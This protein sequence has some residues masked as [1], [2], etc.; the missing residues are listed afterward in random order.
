M[1]FVRLNKLRLLI[2]CIL[3][4]FTGAYAQSAPQTGA[5]IITAADIQREHPASVSDL[6]RSRAGSDDSSGTITM[7]GV[8]GVAVV[9]N[10]MPSTLSDVNH[11]NL[12][13]IERIEIYRG[14]ASARF[15]SNAMGGAIVVTTR[16]GAEAHSVL[17]L[18]G[19]SSGSLGARFGGDWNS[20]GWQAG[21]SLK[22]ESERRHKAVTQAP[23]SNQITVEPERTR[24]KAV[25]LRGG[26]REGERKVGVD[27]KQTDTLAHFG[28]PNWW[29]HLVVNS[30]RVDAAVPL[31]E[32]ILE[33]QTGRE[34]YDDPGL[35][36]T[37]TGT[38][39][40]GL[41]PSRYMLGSGTKDEGELTLTWKG[42]E[43][44]TRIGTI[45]RRTRDRYAIRPY[46][47]DS[48]IFVLDSVTINRALFAHL[49]RRAG[50]SFKAAIDG[51]LD[52]YEYPDIYV[53]D[54]AGTASVP[55]SGAAKQA[56]N[57]KLE[58]SWEA[59]ERTQLNASVGTGFVAPT[60]DQLYYTDKGAASWMLGNPELKP[61]RSRT[62]DIGVNR[63]M[64]ESGLFSAT[65][66][67]TSWT[68]RIG[69]NILNYGVPLVRQFANIGAV[70]SQGL[71]FE[72]H[73]KPAEAWTVSVNY[74]YNRALIVRDDAHPERVGNN[75]PDMPR[76]KLNA[77]IGYESGDLSGRLALRA[78]S[79][80]YTDE[81]N[82]L[83]DAQGYRWQKG[84]Y[85]V[86]DVSFTRRFRYVDAV[87]ALDN[88]FNRQY[89]IGFFRIG[90]PR[91]MR[92]ELSMRI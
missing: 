10:G 41:L 51:R 31:A 54:S 13:D 68:D 60:P 37:G 47:S 70:E 21:L 86:F 33:A 77:A 74:T 32:A 45:Y 81:A 91:L 66:F 2:G 73:M 11:L 9:L 30:L 72:S 43:G 75:L 44:E 23:Y 67:R 76:H 48:D 55:S 22:D 35:L 59:S 62:W 83:L 63:R 52:R 8:L 42:E 53:F 64:G 36:D 26:Y 88:V 58:L 90:Q 50:E 16:K 49:D 65:Y 84:G 17:T 19:S 71:E 92:F 82:T 56:F 29:E 38:D 15:G 40:A 28:R 61:Q 25:S 1:Y 85:A 14:A 46:D 34:V 3:W 18:L 6:L 80:A 79:A 39:T 27:L 7:R 20:N 4:G 87:L 12:Q 57:P 24:G 69:I 89:A 5:S 78:L